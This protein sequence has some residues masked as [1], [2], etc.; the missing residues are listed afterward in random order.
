MIT[1]KI[2]SVLMA[3]LM[4]SEECFLEDIVLEKMGYTSDKNLTVEGFR[5]LISMSEET[6]TKLNVASG[7]LFMGISYNAMIDK[8]ITLYAMMLHYDKDPNS[9]LGRKYA[10]VVGLAKPRSQIDLLFSGI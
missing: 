10:E 7:D 6:Y 3:R 1:V 8:L 9:A 5:A 2:A 4:K